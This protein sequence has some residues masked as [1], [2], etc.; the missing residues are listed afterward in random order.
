MAFPKMLAASGLLDIVLFAFVALGFTC[1]R[2]TGLEKIL[3]SYHSRVTSAFNIPLFGNVQT[4][5]IDW[6]G[7]EN[8]KM[9]EGRH[10]TRWNEFHLLPGVPEAIGRLNRAGVPVV[11]VSNQRGI[12]QGLCTSED[13]RAIHDAFQN[14]LES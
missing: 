1:L 10:V 8:E 7:V 9:P 13:V 14:Q 5:F 6:D 12:A 11:V 4:A 2:A 3:S